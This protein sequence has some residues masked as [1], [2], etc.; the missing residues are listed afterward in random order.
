MRI[1]QVFGHGWILA[2]VLF[3]VFIALDE[4]EVKRNAK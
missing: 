3:C 2:L 1:H 4:V